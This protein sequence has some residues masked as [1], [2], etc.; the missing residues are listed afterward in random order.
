[1]SADPSRQGL[2][3][4]HALIVVAAII[5]AVT[6]LKISWPSQAECTKAG[7]AGA[8]SLRAVVQNLRLFL[9]FAET[10]FEVEW[11]D[12]QRHRV[13]F[14]EGWPFVTERAWPRVQRVLI[15]TGGTLATVLIV[16]NLGIVLLGRVHRKARKKHLRGAEIVDCK[17]LTKIT[18]VQEPGGLSIGNVPIPRALEPLSF[19]FAGSPGAGKSQCINRLVFQLR[20]RGDA[21]VVAD[22][23]AELFA[24]AV[25]PGDALLN[26]FD[27][28]TE[29]WSPF[30]EIQS[31]GDAERI[32]KSIIPSAEGER[33]EWRRYA[34]QLLEITMTQLLERGKA[35]NGWLL[36]YCCS[37]ADEEWAQLVEDTPARPWFAPAN[38]R[39][40]SNVRAAISTFVTPLRYL[41]PEAGRDAFSVTRWTR[42]A[43]NRGAV[44]WL[45]YR[46]DTRDAVAT[47]VATW[48]DLATVA[49][50]SMRP[51]RERRLWLV[52]DELAA[53]GKVDSLQKALA[54]GRKYGL[55]AIAGYQSISQLRELYGPEG[56]RA[57]LSCLQTKTA[58][59]TSDFESAR[60][61]A[62]DLGQA[63]VF[64]D[65]FSSSGRIGELHSQSRREARTIEQAV[66]PAE[67]QRLKPLNGFLKLAGDYPIARVQIPPVAAAE[68]V[69][70]WIPNT[71]L[72]P[73]ITKP[74]EPGDEGPHTD[75][76]EISSQTETDVTPSDDAPDH[77]IAVDDLE[78]L[79]AYL[80]Q[81][82]A[83]DETEESTK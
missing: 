19:L 5:A 1:M 41:S 9:P 64:R 65:E 83:G 73:R 17:R 56:H 25:Q 35:T 67:I 26:V 39:M 21:A 75:A 70:P 45:P 20:D 13:P 47:L 42:D 34:Q 33:G 37:A 3:L 16:G 36:Y 72:N 82:D 76:A 59:S 68:R 79:D 15:T 50:L 8:C 51:D 27:R 44:L 54:Q 11:T 29:Q 14:A 6:A 49:A 32:V 57:L 53:I 40:F 80:E 18:Q 22:A 69:D 43:R 60:S 10:T 2:F 52:I 28:R 71:D 61:L 46:E 74:A 48:L 24:S 7:D 55:A 31:H 12:G 58:L 78:S 62:E 81:V 38:D 4:L 66:L 30:A 23:G 63:E 77:V